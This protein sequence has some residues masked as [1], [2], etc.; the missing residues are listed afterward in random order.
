M[1]IVSL[2][3]G[4]QKKIPGPAIS[5][6]PQ[7]SSRCAVCF[8]ACLQT[9]LVT[10]NLKLKLGYKTHHY[11]GYVRPDEVMVALR[12]LKNRNKLYASINLNSSWLEDSE[13]DDTELWTAMTNVPTEDLATVTEMVHPHSWIVM[14][15][16]RDGDC[17]FSAVFR[18][19]SGEHSHYTAESLRQAVVD[20]LRENPYRCRAY[21]SL[22]YNADN[23]KT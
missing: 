23:A 13:K 22:P 14:D 9:Q 7:I 11:Q 10:M 12:W 16:P 20:H 21:V 19:V 3:T 6:C 18:Q 4:Q 17:M 15:V 8:H 1:R 2:A 5:M